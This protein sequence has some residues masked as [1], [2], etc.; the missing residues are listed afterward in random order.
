[1]TEKTLLEKGY[2]KYESD[3]INIFYHKDICEHAGECVKGD[4]ATFEVERRPWIIPPKT[5][6]DAE[7][8]IEVIKRCPSGALKYQ[9]KNSEEILP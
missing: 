9:Y 5:Q 4:P 3:P 7:K 2:R 1:M 8:T 6:V